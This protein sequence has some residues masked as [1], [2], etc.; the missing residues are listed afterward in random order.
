MGE[1]RDG[2]IVK[3]DSNVHLSEALTHRQIESD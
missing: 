2:E 3:Y 1:G